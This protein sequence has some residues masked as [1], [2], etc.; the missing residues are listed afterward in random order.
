MP[1]SIQLLTPF[2]MSELTTP[3]L[4]AYKNRLLKAVDGPNEGADPNWD[5]T[6]HK[7]RDDWKATMDACKTLLAKREHSPRKVRGPAKPKAKDVVRTSLLKGVLAAGGVET[8]IPAYEGMNG[9][10]HYGVERADYR[11]FRLWLDHKGSKIHVASVKNFNRWATSRLYEG[12]LPRTLGE[13]NEFLTVGNW[14]GYR[15]EPKP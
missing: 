1:K 13:L 15:N 7:A 5:E 8:T 11:G 14:G 2:Q 12:P 9:D 3:R 6:I 4:L 10:A